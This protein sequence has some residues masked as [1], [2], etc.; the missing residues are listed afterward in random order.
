[1][2]TKEIKAEIAKLDKAIFIEQ[3]ADFMDWS[4]YYRLIARKEELE[5]ILKE[6]E[7]RLGWLTAIFISKTLLYFNVI[8]SVSGAP[9]KKFF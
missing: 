8:K 2:T 4:N 9:R 6:E 7:K 3:M 5:K 1:M